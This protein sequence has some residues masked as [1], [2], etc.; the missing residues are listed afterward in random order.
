MFPLTDEVGGR[1]EHIRAKVSQSPIL[2]FHSLLN[3]RRCCPLLMMGR[4]TVL[5][6]WWL[7][8]IHRIDLLFTAHRPKP[9]N[10]DNIHKLEYSPLSRTLLVEQQHPESIGSR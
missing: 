6:R 3:L 1:F 4:M 8:I 5:T 10:V 2:V 9:D 7:P